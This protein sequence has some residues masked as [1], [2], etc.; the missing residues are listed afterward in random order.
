M[1]PA[2]DDAVPD[3]SGNSVPIE[4]LNT[5]TL[6]SFK[7]LL[8]HLKVAPNEKTKVPS[9]N[10]ASR[11]FELGDHD[12]AQLIRYVFLGEATDGATGDLF[13]LQDEISKTVTDA[14][15]AM[16][17]I[18]GKDNQSAVKSLITLVITMANRHEAQIA[19]LK[20][21]VLK[22][23]GAHETSLNQ[24]K[25]NERKRE[26]VAKVEQAR[27]EYMKEVVDAELR[28]SIDD[29]PVDVDKDGNTDVKN[30]TDNI[31]KHFKDKAASI[32]H[33]KGRFTARPLRKK[34]KNGNVSPFCIYA[35]DPAARDTIRE[36]MSSAGLQP[37]RY[38]NKSTYTAL[39]DLRASYT[40]AFPNM[41]IMIRPS[42]NGQKLEIKTKAKVGNSK[43]ALVESS[44]FPLP[45]EVLNKHG[46]ESDPRAKWEHFTVCPP[47]N[48]A[49]Q[50]ASSQPASS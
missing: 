21:V 39:K 14:L 36:N 27:A 31:L 38:L 34:P 48:T 6:D 35:S 32:D 22:L 7:R 37:G 43:W 45:Y 10:E 28:I 15:E 17:R 40:K 4:Q 41:L 8:D 12:V 18:K 46:L 47:V 1:A 49:N 16:S 9:L 25:E 2:V 24:H 29:V 44:F 5:D 23:C 42:K 20:H 3:N 30:P 11:N 33:L 26:A 13:N 19:A 50:S